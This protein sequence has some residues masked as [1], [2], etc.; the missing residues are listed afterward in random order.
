MSR[1]RT[2]SPM[3]IRHAGAL[4]ALLTLVAHSTA[5]EMLAVVHD[6]VPARSAVAGPT[7]PKDLELF[8]D[9]LLQENMQRWHIPGAVFVFVKNGAVFFQKGYGFA[10][11]ENRAPV[12]PEKTLFRV[13]SIS[14]LVTA[15]AVMQLKERG[16]L[17]LQD[18][19]N[20][21][22]HR[23]QIAEKYDR[24][25]TFAD[26]LT[27]TSGLDRQPIGMYSKGNS[28]VPT[29]GD[30]LASHKPEQ[31]RPPGSLFQ[32]SNYGIALAG[33]A[34]EEISGMPFAEFVEQNIFEPL[35]MKK[36]SF[37]LDPDLLKDLA[38]GYYFRD[39]QY[40][41]IK[42]EHLNLA[43]AG[44][45][46][47]TGADMARFLIAHLQNG[48]YESGRILQDA[49]AQEMHRQH[50]AY[51][52][53]LP[54]WAYGFYEAR[55]NGQRA[56]LHSGNGRGFSSML[57]LLPQKNMG[58]FVA[59]NSRVLEIH[60][61]F[62]HQFFDRYFPAK[63][64]SPAL[65]AKTT[66]KADL[67]RF[68][69][70]Y[71][72][73]DYPVKSIYKFSLLQG[74][75]REISLTAN[76]DGTLNAFSGRW[77]QTAPLLF[78]RLNRE[79]FLSFKE[80]K[81][82]R[83]THMFMM[84]DMP[85]TLEKMN[86][87]DSLAS[88]PWLIQAFLVIFLLGALTWPAQKFGWLRQLKSNR[89][90]RQGETFR[91]VGQWLSVAICALNLCFLVGIINQFDKNQLI[92]GVPI[93]ILALL[94]IALLSTVLTFALPVFTF[95]A[96]KNRYGSFWGRLHYSLTSITALLF[97]LFLNYWNLLGFRL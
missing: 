21:Y 4:I 6:L 28:N 40:Y 49:T 95:A 67:S 51:H 37:R 32:Y 2:L 43:P 12:L 17:N 80:N 68:V 48:R 44:A 76:D 69:G 13:A 39:G 54:G 96:W 61:K 91:R 34:V 8:L 20:H 75:R 10:D 22:L 93:R 45:L 26:L 83:I 47:S 90:T 33:F 16:L 82:G 53:R 56:I 38:G 36:S 64:T 60:Q 62:L 52:P 74:K 65:V 46:I 19:V 31:L 88:Q 29:L 70:R 58:F 86:D 55:Y 9:A 79:A 24:P 85:I 92:Y 14:K 7:D 11:L 73:Y 23:F 87:V 35:E 71:R 57:F 41:R 50:F 25:I 15:T 1:K 81:D 5:Q 77:V 3:A 66:A 84:R 30:F 78:K 27:H 63:P 89:P 59:Y 94:G 97:V 72:Y 18:D 42:I